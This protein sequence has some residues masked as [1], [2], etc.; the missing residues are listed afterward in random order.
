MKIQILGIIAIIALFCTLIVFS[1]TINPAY[2]IISEKDNYPFF[3]ESFPGVT[4]KHSLSPSIEWIK[5]IG[6][7]DSDYARSVQQ[8]RDGGYIIGGFSYSF[9]SFGDIWLIKTDSQGEVIWN[10]QALSYR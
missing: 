10:Y 4:E 7:Y 8:T 5:K 3:Q 2:G 9:G 6:S 1:G